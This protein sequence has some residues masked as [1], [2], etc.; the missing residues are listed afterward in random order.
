MRRTLILAFCLA[1]SMLVAVAVSAPAA[2]AEDPP[3]ARV[4]R[5]AIADG[6]V[7][8]R[9]AGGAWTDS[10]VNV[11]V[12]AG[13]SLRSDAHGRAI[14]GIGDERVA[15]AADSEI[16]FGRLDSEATQIMLRR[17][18][19]GLHV[20]T[21]DP[22]HSIEIDVPSGGIWLLA[23]GDYDITAGEETSSGR[24]AVL[25]GRARFVGTGR[26]ATIAAGSATA[27][28]GGGAPIS[29]A[30]ADDFAAWWQ[31]A[32]NADSDVAALRHVSGEMTGYH[33]LDAAGDWEIVAGYGAVWFPKATPADWAPYRD[34][35]WR[36]IAPWGWTWID[37][38]AWGFAPSHY[39]RW[40]R[41]ATPGSDGA[42]RWGWVPG[43]PVA[44]P[45]YVPAAVAFLGTAGV[46]LSYPDASGPA[47]GWFPLA[48]GD[49]Y[50]P[51]YTDDL[52]V[53]RQAN[54]AA[55]PDAAA[56]A[57]GDDGGPSDAVVNGDY[58]N[59]R[60]ASVV[61]RAVFVGGQP[62]AAALVQLPTQRLA[63]APLLAGSPGIAPPEP[64]P[65]AVAAAKAHLANTVHALARIAKVKAAKPIAKIAELARSAHAAAAGRLRIASSPRPQLRA[66]IIAVSARS[67]RAHLHL[68]AAHRS[69]IVRRVRR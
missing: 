4:G 20:A 10:P 56:L 11:P 15:L 46:G 50:W 16:N 54:A 25:A 33:Q 51:R 7:A 59:R 37:A 39:G 63:N 64:H 45:V 48:P 31:P 69:E 58:P 47:V 6:E 35:R 22:A 32:A 30:V 17:G 38:A 65:V 28:S 67:S 23:A 12:S 29:V 66:H 27:L 44:H 8:T 14:V 42:E 49:V 68:A 13:T 3:I 60:F 61:P 9:P 18:R 34:G 52:R 5:I 36:W 55:V 2:K 21:L 26:D 24:L 53:I 1:A 62:V 40:A 43:R 41:I 19:L 57:A